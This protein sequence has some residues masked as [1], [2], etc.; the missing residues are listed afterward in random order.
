MGGLV[1]ACKFQA[2]LEE[3]TRQLQRTQLALVGAQAG[4]EDV[5]ERIGD[6]RFC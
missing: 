6:T 4:G 1:R 5:P 2:Q 3:A